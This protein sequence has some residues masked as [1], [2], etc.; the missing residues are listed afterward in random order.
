MD[1]ESHPTTLQ[2]ENRKKVHELLKNTHSRIEKLVQKTYQ[3][4][5]VAATSQ[6][7]QLRTRITGLISEAEKKR[8]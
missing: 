1:L 5:D 8:T 6:L 4:K 3:Q 2:E 7:R